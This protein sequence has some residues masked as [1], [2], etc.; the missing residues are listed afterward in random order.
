MNGIPWRSIG[1]G[2]ALMLIGALWTGSNRLASMETSLKYVTKQIDAMAV[3]TSSRLLA[4]EQ[5][6]F[7]GRL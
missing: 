4:L 6:R 3:D 5:G 2:L 1:A 7:G